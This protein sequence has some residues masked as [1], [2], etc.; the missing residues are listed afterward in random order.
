MSIATVVT[1]G[2]GNGTLSGSISGVILRGYTI[3][4]A[5]KRRSTQRPGHYI[6]AEKHARDRLLA[7]QQDDEEMLAI[8]TMYL[9]L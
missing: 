7:I 2:F 5:R 4:E 1:R 3:G 8:I 9:R 6:T